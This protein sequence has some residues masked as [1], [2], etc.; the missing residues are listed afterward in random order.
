LQHGDNES[1]LTQTSRRHDATTRQ[2][3]LIDRSPAGMFSSRGVG[4][5]SEI[6][7]TTTSPARLPSP[8]SVLNLSASFPNTQLRSLGSGSLRFP[9]GLPPTLD[10]LYARAGRSHGGLCLSSRRLHLFPQS[11]D[12]SQMVA[13]HLGQAA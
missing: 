2:L 4:N 9:A 1:S 13:G 10:C 3:L 6:P 7:D 8:H 12:I 5:C 11:L